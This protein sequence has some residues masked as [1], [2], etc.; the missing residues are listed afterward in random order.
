VAGGVLFTL[1]VVTVLTSAVWYLRSQGL[2][3]GGGY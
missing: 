3:A 1:L 2:L